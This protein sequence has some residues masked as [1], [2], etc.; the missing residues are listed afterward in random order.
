MARHPE[1]SEGSLK[2]PVEREPNVSRPI[3]YYT[4]D[5]VSVFRSERQRDTL[6]CGII[7]PRRSSSKCAAMISARCWA[8]ST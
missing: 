2:G 7:A 1:R 6:G 8:M 5:D 3:P 4:R